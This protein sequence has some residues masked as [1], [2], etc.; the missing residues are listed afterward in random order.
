MYAALNRI[1][2]VDVVE[3]P[4]PYIGAVVVDVPGRA[5]VQQS[6]SVGKFG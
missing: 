6:D 1:I 4:S 3:A 5:A 2:R